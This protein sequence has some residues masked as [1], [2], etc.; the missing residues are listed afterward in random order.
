MY[1]LFFEINATQYQKSK[2]AV[3]SVLQLITTEDKQSAVRTLA[4]FMHNI[5]QNAENTN[6]DLNG[7]IPTFTDI[8]VF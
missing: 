6:S 4:N 7:L 1:V 3:P 2:L 8:A 5:P